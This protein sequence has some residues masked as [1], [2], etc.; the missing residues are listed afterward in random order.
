MPTD[1]IFFRIHQIILSAHTA[2]IILPSLYTTLYGIMNHK[3]KKLKF[4]H[5]FKCIKAPVIKNE[6]VKLSTG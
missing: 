3:P 2:F 1:P 6:D 5:V 4:I